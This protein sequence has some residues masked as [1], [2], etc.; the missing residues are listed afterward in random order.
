MYK[1]LSSRLGLS[2]KSV[3]SDIL[4][5]QGTTGVATYYVLKGF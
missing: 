4:E 1:E 3:I 2:D 5:K